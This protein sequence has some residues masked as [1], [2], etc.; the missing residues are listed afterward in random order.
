MTIR[1]EYV[2]VW[3]SSK[4]SNHGLMSL[5]LI[6]NVWAWTK[7][8]WHFK[9]NGLDRNWR[10]IFIKKQN[11]YTHTPPPSTL[12][13][14]PA[15]PHHSSKLP[16]CG[17]CHTQSLN[18]W[19]LMHFIRKK[20]MKTKR[21]PDILTTMTMKVFLRPQIHPCLCCI[22]ISWVSSS[23]NLLHYTGDYCICSNYSTN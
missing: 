16:T 17:K 23:F 2:T 11:T 13:N 14:K 22:L 19:T 9:W 12:T 4:L 5:L 1:W 3:C 8:H 6:K 7:M 21:D 15:L 20:R 18:V 10:N